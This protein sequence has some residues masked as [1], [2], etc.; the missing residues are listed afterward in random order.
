MVKKGVQSVYLTHLG[1]IVQLVPRVEAVTPNFYSV[2]S[3]E[4][5]LKTVSVSDT[6]L[7]LI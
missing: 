1:R 5:F 3:S 4:E 6:G 2:V 7:S